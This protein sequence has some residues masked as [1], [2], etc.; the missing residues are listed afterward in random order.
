MTSVGR[1]LDHSINADGASPYVFKLNRELIH[2]AG[3]LLP[4]DEG[5]VDPVYS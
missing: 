1:K 5:N 4:P 3:S 2:R